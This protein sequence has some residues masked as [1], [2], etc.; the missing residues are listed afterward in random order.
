M[1]QKTWHPASEIFPILEGRP[2][3]EFVADIRAHGLREPIVLHPDDRI[4]D[5]RN[6]ARACEAAGVEP[7]YT[8]WDG[9]GSPVA[10]V[11]SLNLHRRH[12]SESQRSMIG[13]RL[14][15][16]QKG[17]RLDRSKDPSSITQDTA[18]DLLNTSVPSIKR[19]TS[20]LREG[21]PATIEAVDRGVLTVTA[22]AADIRA[23]REPVEVRE[24]DRP[25]PTP[26]ADDAEAFAARLLEW[27]GDGEC[28]RLQT[29][30][31]VLQVPMSTVRERLDA[32]IE[33]G[34]HTLVDRIG[35]G[36]DVEYRILRGD[37]RMID[38][39]IV[40][41]EL[42]RLVEQVDAPAIGYPAIKK[43]ATDLRAVIERLARRSLL[44]GGALGTNRKSAA[45]RSRLALEE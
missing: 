23:R 25:A 3:D 36:K 39:G 35:C 42:N 44:N 19:A 8:T 28:H 40:L 16:L 12:L 13:A 37:H 21:D 22:A 10:F 27:F 11:V 7:R 18:A 1:A 45:W 31:V 17:M 15:T 9:V 6:R 2:F 20:V 43:I 30:V 41:L 5:G 26:P 38:A 34:A 32:M 14:A 24:K 33:T 29:I 4:L